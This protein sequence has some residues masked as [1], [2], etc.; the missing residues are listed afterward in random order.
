MYIYI[1]MLLIS[2]LFITLYEKYEN[3]I[4]KTL[5]AIAGVL[6]FFLISALRYD[7][8]TDYFYR[9]VPDFN[10]ILNGIDVTNL[11]IGFKLIIQFC[12]LFTNDYQWLFVITSGIIMLFFSSRIFK[13]SKSVL[14]SFCIFFLAGFFFQSMNILRQYIAMGIIFFTS[15]FLINKKYL[16]F[17]LGIILAFFIHNSSIVGVILLLLLNKEWFRPRNVIILAL[18]ILILG[19]PMMNLFNGIISNTRFGVYINS[20]YDRGEMRKLT[21]LSNSI[22]YAGIYILYLIK[23]KNNKIQEDDTFFI[24]VQGVTL[25]FILLSSKFYLFF[26][27][28]YYFMIF[29]ILSIPYFIKTVDSKDLVLIVKNLIKKILKKDIKISERLEKKCALLLSVCAIVYF[30]VILSYTNILNNDEEVLPYKTIFQKEQVQE[31]EE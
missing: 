23:K 15:R 10:N 8:G 27:I 1:I 12:L 29:Q 30:S 26:R 9:Y 25:I 31:V 5:C 3:K 16:W 28:S 7:V 22:I 24:N 4:I 19:T 21:I 20:S 13:D 11:E 14:L 18:V 2:V 6:P 17:I